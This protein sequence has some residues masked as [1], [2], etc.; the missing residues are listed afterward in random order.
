MFTNPIVGGGNALIRTAIRSPDFVTGVSGWSI[1]KDGSAEFNDLDARGSIEAGNG[2]VRLNS[3]GIFVQGTNHQFDI[4]F[5]AGFLARRFPDTGAYSQLTV[6]SPPFGGISLYNM[7][8]PTPNGNDVEAGSLFAQ[9]FTA[10][11]SEQP[12]MRWRSP[13]FVGRSDN[14][15]TITGQSEASGDNDGYIELDAPLVSIRGIALGRGF[16]EGNGTTAPSAAVGNTETTVI[17]VPSTQYAADRTF[18][19]VISGGVSVSVANN[20]PLFRIRKTNTAG[21]QLDFFRVPCINTSTTP[22]SY[23]LYFQTAAVAVTAAIV[24]TVIGSA[25]FTATLQ[26][27]PTS[28]CTI[29]VYD[30]GQGGVRNWV[31]TLV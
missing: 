4:N 7:A 19:I 15:I 12:A 2:T 22:M 11:G 6:L 28:P 20:T 5:V 3:G 9:L 17:T 10:T 18:R 25:A 31:P 1:N 23:T 27:Q 21:Q 29:N 26:G 14:A 16:I 24:L 8:D 13:N 30:D